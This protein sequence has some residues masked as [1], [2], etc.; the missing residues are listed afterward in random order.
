M[1]VRS[2]LLALLTEGPKHG[3]QLKKELEERTGALWQVNVGQVYTT[4]GRLE[5]DGLVVAE[6]VADS[7]EHRP[8]RLTD[9][10]R[11]EVGEWFGTPR[12]RVLP[13]RDEL[14]V[15]LTLA[16]ELGHDA[17]TVID[18]QRRATTEALQQF[19]RTKAAADEADLARLFALDA[20]IAQIEAELR[21]LEIC[22]ARLAARA[23]G[24]RPTSRQTR[25][26]GR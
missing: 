4:L 25:R 6:G 22:Q 18:D 26:G 16:V 3:F 17:D 7:D 19:T 20:A 5:R 24:S 2:G 9:A 10:G 11:R 8:F 23:T 15:K 14:V 21:W 1:S 13:D 12:P